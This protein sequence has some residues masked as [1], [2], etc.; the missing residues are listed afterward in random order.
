MQVTNEFLQ[1]LRQDYK[2]ATLDASD[3]DNNPIT[4]FKKWFDDA[5]TAQVYEPNVMT[6]ATA[7]KSGRPDARIVLLKG[8]DDD[9]FRFF[10]NYLSAK[11]KQLKRNPYAA[12]VFFW[13]DLERQV[14]IE[15]VV[16]KL[17]KETSEAYFITRP[18]ASQIGAVAS[19]QSQV[20]PD[21][22]VLE[23]RF[24]DLKNKSEGKLITKP[25]H[26]GGY[27]VKPT[28]IEFWQGRRSRLHDRINFELIKGSWVKNRLA[29]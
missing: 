26:W 2:G 27:I 23:E 6:L 15:G 20:I 16:E 19:P 29:P 4:Q 12:L 8:V 21:R 22:A 18:I 9:G 13:P 24:E 7:D 14:R 1:N 25:A 10:T 17:D 28:R 11:G 5:V 3:V